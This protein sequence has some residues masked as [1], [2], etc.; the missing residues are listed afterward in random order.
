MPGESSPDV[1]FEIGHVL[2]IDIVG[3]SQLLITEQS[4]QIQTL[5]E[6][7]R[8]TEQVRRA[9]AEGKLL[10]LPTGDGGALVFRN[11]PEAPV[12]CAIEIAKALKSHPELRVRMGIH[13]GPVNEITDLNEQAN[14][15]GAGINIAQRVMDCGDAGHILLSRHLAEDLEQYPHW[16]Q[17][18]HN[19]GECEVKHGVR[20]GLVNLCRDDIGNP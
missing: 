20:L 19:L 14:I 8:G 17:Y 5:K 15:A 2:F 7:V 16:Q 11:T 3:Y 4:E 13:S 10:R 18:L 1:K 12:L 6:I 9:E